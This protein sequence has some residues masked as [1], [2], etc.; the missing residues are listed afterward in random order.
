MIA[1]NVYT[2]PE[3][4][5]G[6]EDGVWRVFEALE[7]DRPGRG[8]LQEHREIDAIADAFEK[9]V[10]LRIAGEE[11]KGAALT[12]FEQFHN[13]VGSFAGE[14]CVADIGHFMRKVEESLVAVV[15]LGRKSIFFHVI[16]AKALANV[17]EFAAD[18]ESGGGEN[19]GVEGFEKAL[20]ENLA[21]IDGSG[22]EEDTFVAALEPVDVVFFVG[23]EKKGKFLAQF[24]TATR[25]AQK[26]LGLLGERGEFG[27]HALERVHQGIVGFVI[28][29]EEGFAFVAGEREPAIARG[30]SIEEG[31]VLLADALRAA[32]QRGTAKMSEAQGLVGIAGQ[33]FETEIGDLLAEVIAGDIFH[34]VGFVEN[35]G[36]IFREN[37][38]KVVLPE[39]EV[40]EEKMVIDD[41]E[42]GV[43]G[44]SLHGGEEALFEFR[45]LFPGAGI[46]T[47][48]D[49]RPEVGIVGEKREFGAIAG[50]G[51][52]GP[53]LNLFEG[54]EF[55]EAAKHGL[56]GKGVQLGAAKEIGAALHDRDL[57]LG[58]EVLL[59]EGDVFLVELF[60]EGLGG[61]GN[62]DA[63][64]AAN[65]GQEVGEGFAGTGA[66]FDDG[67]MM[68]LEGVINGLGHL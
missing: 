6:E 32:K 55:F 58:S 38:A 29:F 67:V 5:S 27:F 48:V 42:I 53:F 47:G 15:E 68:I 64:A 41:D 50:F 14:S 33:F 17:F 57:E 13:F 66:G 44:A 34:F 18:G 19:N 52:L 10:H 28:L 9:I 63:A 51:D 65:G 23:L 37:A 61:R 8:A 24:E 3:T 21:D 54:V 1:G 62:N 39:G 25:D 43:F 30:E 36:G 35:D 22:G 40:G 4:G 46:T 11:A 2:L 7:K 56:I 60:L 12:T 20:A 59:E 16:E 31:A 26:F 49:A 45:T